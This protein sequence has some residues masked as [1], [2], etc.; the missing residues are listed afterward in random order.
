MLRFADFEDFEEF[1]SIPTQEIERQCEIG[2]LLVK[3]YEEIYEDLNAF[4]S[5]IF[6]YAPETLGWGTGSSMSVIDGD[7][8]DEI[9]YLKGWLADMIQVRDYRREHATYKG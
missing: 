5:G 7:F 4:H 6:L 8:T 9:K 3:K 1:E 2:E